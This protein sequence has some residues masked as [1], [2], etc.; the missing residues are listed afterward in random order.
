MFPSNIFNAYIYAIT[1]DP[2]MSSQEKEQKDKKA[3][4]QLWLMEDGYKIKENPDMNSSFRM[5]AENNAG[6]WVEVVQ[7]TTR[8]DQ[9]G[10]VTTIVLNEMQKA[11]FL[12]MDE[13]KRRELI[14]EL[15]SGLL[16]MGIAYMGLIYPLEKLTISRAVYYDGLNKN[17]FMD[18]LTKVF[19]AFYYVANIYEKYFGE[20][21]PTPPVTTEYIR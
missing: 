9:I 13:G 7:L 8:P 1:N 17:N 3:Q 14:R 11:K 15:R 19:Y 16:M 20:L 21:S 12:Q 10:I 2:N 6:N 5:V 18:T 4:A